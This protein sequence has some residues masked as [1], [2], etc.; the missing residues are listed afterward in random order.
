MGKKKKNKIIGCSKSDKNKI[1][2]KNE[3]KGSFI[4]FGNAKIQ[5]KEVKK[6]TFNINDLF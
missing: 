3:I 2:K 1:K 4:N 5:D 6:G